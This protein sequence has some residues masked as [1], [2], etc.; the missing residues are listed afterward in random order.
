MTKEALKINNNIVNKKK[1]HMSK[2]SVDLMPVNF[3]QI[4]VSYKFNYNED[5]F[6][7]FIGYQKGE[8]VKLLCIISP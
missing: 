4:V 3:D 1:F 7:D 2:E 6:K 8:I 5:V